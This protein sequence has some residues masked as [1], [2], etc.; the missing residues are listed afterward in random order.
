MKRSELTRVDGYDNPSL[1][2]DNIVA[3]RPSIQTVNCGEG[4]GGRPCVCS[5]T[6]WLESPE[7]VGGTKCVAD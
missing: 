5:L 2:A 7:K 1:A 3:A 6:I 4:V